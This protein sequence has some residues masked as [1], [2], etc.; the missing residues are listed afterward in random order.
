MADEYPYR[1]QVLRDGERVGTVESE[2][3]GRAIWRIEHPAFIDPGE[4][5][6]IERLDRALYA[7][8]FEIMPDD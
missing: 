2:Y 6:T 4:P 5:R 3:H 8:G 7:L 1:Y